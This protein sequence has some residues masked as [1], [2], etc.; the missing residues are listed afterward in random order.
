MEAEYVE[1][2]LAGVESGNTG[3]KTDD[4]DGIG[5]LKQGGL[6]FRNYWSRQNR[7]CFKM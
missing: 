7:K 4:R 2:Q 6:Y 3:I 1:N 5:P